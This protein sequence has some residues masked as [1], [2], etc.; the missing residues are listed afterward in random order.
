MEKFTQKELENEMKLLDN[1]ELK[2]IT[3]IIKQIKNSQ[4][5]GLTVLE[6]IKLRI[7]IKMVNN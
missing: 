6:F 5:R 2:A 3:K 7:K 1:S 4:L